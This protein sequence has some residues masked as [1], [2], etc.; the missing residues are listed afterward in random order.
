MPTDAGCQHAQGLL[1][2]AY[3]GGQ[4]AAESLFI[5]VKRR[6]DTA[7]SSAYGVDIGQVRRLSLRDLT[8]VGGAERFTKPYRQSLETDKS[9]LS[10][11]QP[12]AYLGVRAR[13]ER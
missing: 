7:C 10:R 2:P 12:F 1:L 8:G 9:F 3:T 6:V 4:R 5:N 13:V 11:H